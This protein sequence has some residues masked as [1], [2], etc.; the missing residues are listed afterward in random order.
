MLTWYVGS[1]T[2]ASCNPGKFGR[3]LQRCLEPELW[4]MLLRTY[5]DAD[6]DRTWDV[7]DAMCQLF[8]I[9]AR[10]TAERFGFEYPYADDEKVSAHLKH[11][12]SLPRDAK[13]IY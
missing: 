1:K 4:D 7:L 9:T 5:S 12:R 6:Y 3:H 8:R 2:G 10:S 11:V 13:E